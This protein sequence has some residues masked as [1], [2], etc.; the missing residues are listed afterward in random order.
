[1]HYPITF[2]HPKVKL[3]K[4][5]TL[6]WRP[7]WLEDFSYAEPVLPSCHFSPSESA[8]LSGN[9]QKAW[10]H[11]QASFGWCALGKPSQS[12]TSAVPETDVIIIKYTV[13][14]LESSR[15]HSHPGLWKSCLPQN[16][17]LV[18]KMG[19]FCFASFLGLFLYD[20]QI[21]PPTANICF[22]F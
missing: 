12:L 18:P 11:F 10:T 20:F 3:Y 14:A 19:D 5:I 2:L 13:N 1:M 4:G 21:P 22:L 9:R 6:R 7:L 8:S 15:N 16:R 17:P